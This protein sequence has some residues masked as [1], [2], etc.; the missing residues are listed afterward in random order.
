MYAWANAKGLP[1]VPIFTVFTAV[2]VAITR[3]QTLRDRDE[4]IRTLEA[5]AL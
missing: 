1:R 3:V 2:D 4:I 5:V